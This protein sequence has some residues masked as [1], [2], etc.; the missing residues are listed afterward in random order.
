MQPCFLC[1]SV[2]PVRVR[3]YFFVI[4]HIPGPIAF[5]GS[6]S[7]HCHTLCTADT[8]VLVDVRLEVVKRNCISRTMLKTYAAACTVV[9][10]AELKSGVLFH[11]ALFACTTHSERF[12][13]TCRTRCRMAGKMSNRKERLALN[14]TGRNEN[15]FIYFAVDFNR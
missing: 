2:P 4:F 3:R 6:E 13:R 15:F 9:A 8:F 1:P 14:Y 7:A 5:D 12:Q 10:D 11:L